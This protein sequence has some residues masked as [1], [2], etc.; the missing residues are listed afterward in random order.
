ME[1][2]KLIGYVLFFGLIIS[3]IVIDTPITVFIDVASVIMVIGGTFA[4]ILVATG[5]DVLTMFDQKPSPFAWQAATLG[6][7]ITALIGGSMGHIKMFSNL[8]DPSTIG[9]AMA[10]CLLSLL[11][12][13]IIV[14]VLAMP[15]VDQY[16]LETKRFHEF[17]MGRTMVIVFPIFAMMMV[18]L[19]F[20]ILLFAMSPTFPFL[21]TQMKL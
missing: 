8:S 17:S 3:L 4:I 10:L 2:T 21:S 14:A 12:G 5:T 13:M 1:S 16:I 20:L 6:L 9:P 11:Y 15:K 18:L 19:A 7:M